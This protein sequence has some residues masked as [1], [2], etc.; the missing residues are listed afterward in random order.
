MISLF[1]S[2]CL[3]KSEVCAVD[4]ALAGDDA[5]VL[6]LSFSLSVYIS[7]RCVTWMLLLLVMTQVCNLSL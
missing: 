5:G 3:H 4:A 6:Y 7:W 2:I 1:L